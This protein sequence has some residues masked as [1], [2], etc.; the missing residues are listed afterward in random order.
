MLYLQNNFLSELPN[1]ICHLPNL[2]PQNTSFNVKNNLLVIPPQKLANR[3]FHFIKKYFR[4]RDN[5]LSGIKP[6]LK[7]SRSFKMLVIG[8]EVK[9]QIVSE[10]AQD[11]TF[12]CESNDICKFYCII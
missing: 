5:S 12:I 11:S 4:D 6:K 2:T 8:D 7:R 1:E 3:G 9:S 10:L